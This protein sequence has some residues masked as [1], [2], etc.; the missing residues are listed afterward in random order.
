MQS[1]FPENVSTFGGDIDGIFW[2]IFYITTVWFFLT[3]GLIVYFIFRYRHRPGQR[4]AYVCGD[5]LKQLAW[6]LVPLAIVVVLDLLIDFRGA[7]VWAK[8]KGQLPPADIVVR[9]TGKQFNWEFL[10]P[11]PD[12]NFD[13]ADDLQ[14]ENDLHVPVGKVVHVALTAKDVIHSFFLPHLRL[15]QDVVP[16]R[17]ITAWFEA[18]KTG[19]YE[20]PCAELCGFGHSGMNG[21]LHVHTPEEY[22]KWLKEKW[23]GGRAS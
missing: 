1:W 17:A 11:G 23:P 15:K 8:I 18:V 12:G 19:E 4:A 3:E 5:S 10:Y 14:L 7:Q 21:K 9:A 13:T 16:G 20:I 22:Q 2:F 6:V